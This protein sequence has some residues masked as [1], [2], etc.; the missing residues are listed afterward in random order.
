[1]QDDLRIQIVDEPMDEPTLIRKLVAKWHLSVAERRALP[2]QT[3][4]ASIVCHAIVEALA[5]SHLYPRD[6]HADDEFDGGLIQLTPDGRCD[7]HW[8]AEVA[9]MRF[10]LMGIE[11]FANALEAAQAWLRRMFPKDIDGV[12]LDWTS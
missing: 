6:W 1:M 2:H 5:A 4:K 12:P 7:I 3:A 9:Y 11:H 10:E 8:K